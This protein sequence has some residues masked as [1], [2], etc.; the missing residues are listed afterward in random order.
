LEK[1][2]YEPNGMGYDNKRKQDLKFM[3]SGLLALETD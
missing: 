3:T 2:Y 1:R